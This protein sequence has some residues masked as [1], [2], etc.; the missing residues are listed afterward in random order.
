MLIS[1]VLARRGEKDII[2]FIDAI[3]S[4]A[5]I[6]VLKSMGLAALATA[7]SQLIHI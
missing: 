1:Y 2:S 7:P 6:V 4:D 5:A 3:M